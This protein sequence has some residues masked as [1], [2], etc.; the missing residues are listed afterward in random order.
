LVYIVILRSKKV[1][2]HVLVIG[3]L[4]SLLR[5]QGDYCCYF[6]NFCYFKL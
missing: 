3:R 4:V 6:I 2:A 1:I 5:Y